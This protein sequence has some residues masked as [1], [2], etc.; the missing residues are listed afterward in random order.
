MSGHQFVMRE[1][2]VARGFLGRLKL[3][4]GSSETYVR[5]RCLNELREPVYAWD[6]NQL[7]LLLHAAP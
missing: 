6:R 4:R 1:G 3:R 5:M 7:Y 2:R